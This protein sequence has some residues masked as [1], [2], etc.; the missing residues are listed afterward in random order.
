MDP[1]LEQVYDDCNCLCS[2]Y[3]CYSAF[4]PWCAN[5]SITESI[6]KKMVQNKAV[7]FE[8]FSYCYNSWWKDCIMS[9]L[10]DVIT[11]H[12][13]CCSMCSIVTRRRRFLMTDQ[14]KINE[15]KQELPHIRYL[16]NCKHCCSWPF[17]FRVTLCPCCIVGSEHE[18]IHTLSDNKTKISGSAYTQVSMS[19]SIVPPGKRF[20]VI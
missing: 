3:C 18:Y 11:Y 10:C 5:A 8:E 20:S 17:W 12:I 9:S 19:E 7:D 1:N 13:C 15:F 4:C 14:A 2:W 6:S 16:K